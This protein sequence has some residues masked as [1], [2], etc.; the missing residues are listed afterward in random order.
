EPL[1]AIGF[2]PDRL[3]PPAIVEI[4]GD[5]LAQPGLEALARRPAQFAAELRCV[6]RIAAV[7]AWPVGD[8]GDQLAVRPMRRARRQLVEEPANRGDDFEV[9]ALAVA[10]DVVALAG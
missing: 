7:V 4:P 9:G 2:R 5:G 3:P 10:T 6:H 1:A 8:K